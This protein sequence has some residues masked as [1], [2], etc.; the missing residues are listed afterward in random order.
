MAIEIKSLVSDAGRQQLLDCISAYREDHGA[1]LDRDPT[2]TAQKYAALGW[3]GVI[4]F[5]DMFA[6]SFGEFGSPAWRRWAG[7]FRRRGIP[8]RCCHVHWMSYV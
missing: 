3:A 8:A 1:A 2:A 7:E 5:P 4:A 6:S